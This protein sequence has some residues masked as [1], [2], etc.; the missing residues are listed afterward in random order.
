LSAH[1]PSLVTIGTRLTV[2]VTAERGGFISGTD[3]SPATAKV[4]K[5]APPAFTHHPKPSITGTHAVGRTLQV[6]H[7]TKGGF[8]PTA[9]TLTYQWLRDGK[10]IN[11]AHGSSYHL[12]AP[13]RG[14]KV[15][16]R[17]TANRPGYAAGHLTTEAISI[18]H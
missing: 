15:S 16:V 2:T 10:P 17:I 9:S 1:L 8:T 7:L 12:T 3:T 13:D 5:G 14:A 11:G 6:G 18:T 4:A